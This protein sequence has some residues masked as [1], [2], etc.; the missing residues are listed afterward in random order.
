MKNTLKKIELMYWRVYRH[1]EDNYFN[2]I[3][4]RIFGHKHHIIKTGLKPAPW[5]D[6]DSRML[7]GIMSL[8]TWFV[9]NDMRK[10]SKEEREEEMKRID[11]EDGGEKSFK[12]CL[13]DQWAKEDAVIEIY[14]WWKNYPN[15]EKENAEILSAWARFGDQFKDN[16]EDF[17]GNR[18]RMTKEQ[19]KE[20]DRLF[21]VHDELEKKLAE[22]EDE[23][24]KRAVELRAY[25][26]S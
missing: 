3:W 12:D 24:L 26:W 4:Y 25:M 20:Y 2:V 22:E 10:W 6:V 9:E 5:Y 7:Y 16:E 13:F 11:S 21:D 8:V 15:R 19:E 23:M 18:S 17:L 14:D 1:I